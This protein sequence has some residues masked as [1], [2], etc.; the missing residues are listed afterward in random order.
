MPK[1]EICSSTDFKVIA[2]EIREGKSNI[3]E[4]NNCNLVIQD[5]AQSRAE[6]ESYY[7][8]EYQN[9]NSLEKE[10]PQTAKEHFESRL[11]TLDKQ[12]AK[13]VPLLNSSMRVLDFGAGTGEVL[14]SIK[15][16]VKEVTG[17]EIHDGF[18]EFMNGELGIEA[19]SD[20][21]NKKDFGDRKFDLIISLNTLD[22][23][24]NPMETLRTLKALL[25]EDGLMY[26]EVPNRDVALNKYLPEENRQKF[27]TFFWH[28]AHYFYF[29]T[30]TI[31][32]FFDKVGL[33]AEISIK[34]EYTFY[35]FL[36]WYFTGNRQLS[37]V[38]ATTGKYLFEGESEFEMKMNEMFGRMEK[39]FHAVLEET[40]TGDSI[41]CIARR[42]STK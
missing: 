19:Y 36:K 41:C 32:K 39:D 30:D 3:C 29:T 40:F 7:N 9:T 28:V 31:Q 11:K 35:N 18:V 17:V 8:E 23:L 12:L 15:N 22:H 6:L 21:I 24:P 37:F 33:I 25:A 1:C 13:I 5:I 16:K 4:C 38:V 10:K 34:H 26:I 2:T 20:D 14:Y 42:K 27:E